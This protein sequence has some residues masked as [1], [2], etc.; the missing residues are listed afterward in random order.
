MG[1]WYSDLFSLGNWAEIP[2][3][4]L[5]IQSHI[6]FYFLHLS[7]NQK[8]RAMWRVRKKRREGKR[9]LSFINVCI[10]LMEQVRV[11]LVL[12]SS[13]MIYISL[14][15]TTEASSTL[16]INS[17]AVKDR[18]IYLLFITEFMG[19]GLLYRTCWEIFQYF[20]SVYFLGRP[21]K[22]KQ[23]L[24]CGTFDIPLWIR[25]CISLALW[26]TDLKQRG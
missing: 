21:W 20:P 15:T 3:W 14:L 4:T 8:M 9:G 16:W 12:V 2:Y 23:A 6:V 13:V 25:Y 24:I 10:G 26:T 5:Q 17:L 22:N 7:R 11:S 19:F 1:W 18:V